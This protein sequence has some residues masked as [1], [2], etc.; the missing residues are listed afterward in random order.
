MLSSESNMSIVLT[1][2]WTKGGVYSIHDFMVGNNT[3][4][5]RPCK[6]QDKITFKFETK[7]IPVSVE[8]VPL[9]LFKF[10]DFE[11]ILSP[12]FDQQILVGKYFMWFFHQYT[13]N[14]GFYYSNKYNFFQMSL[15]RLQP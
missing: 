1:R 10:A 13:T 2:S 7:V 15:A 11:E 4:D 6:N 9:N 5:F 8:K 3:G 14:Y 12:S